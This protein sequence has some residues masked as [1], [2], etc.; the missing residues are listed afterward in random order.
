MRHASTFVMT[1][2]ADAHASRSFLRPN[3]SVF[4]LIAVFNS[5]DTDPASLVDVLSVDRVK[6]DSGDFGGHVIRTVSVAVLLMSF[7]T[8][9]QS[10]T[11]GEATLRRLEQTW[12]DAF[13][14][15]DSIALGRVLAEDWHGQYP[16]GNEDRTQALAAL[17]SDK[18]AIQSLTLGPMRVRILGDI[19]FIQGTDDERST[20]DGKETSGHFTW[21]DIF[22]RRNGRWVAIASQLTRIS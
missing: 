5:V 13:L 8:F 18:A 19:A 21:T 22:A 3:C 10:A 4:F 7:T 17:A 14:H 1:F 16:W 6:A 9:G 2:F 15:K 11:S 12:V 20:F